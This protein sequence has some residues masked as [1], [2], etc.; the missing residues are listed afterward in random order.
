MAV[1]HHC[2]VLIVSNTRLQAMTTIYL[3]LITNQE[4]QAM[5]PHE[6]VLPLQL[7]DLKLSTF[8]ANWESSAESAKEQ[9][10]T[11]SRYLSYLCDREIQKRHSTRLARRVKES[12]LPRDKTLSSFNFEAN[13]SINS[14]QINALAES[15]TW[16]KQGHNIIIFG[17]SGVGK[18]H[19]AAA[20]AYRQ[21][22]RGHRVKFQ[23]ATHIVQ[24]LQ[25]AKVQFRLKDLLVKLDKVPL[26]LLDD[27][28]Y[29]KK[30]K[31]K[32]AFYLN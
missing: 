27:I 26:L 12:A 2:L 28:G 20:I 29:I 7:K 13:E 31:M 23:Q 3:L 19:L 30:M 11:Y 14:A 1:I 22:E 21:I 32:Q 18:T 9:G 15:D 16:I 10:W 25:Q 17:P 6:A 8:N 5:Q 4:I 24:A